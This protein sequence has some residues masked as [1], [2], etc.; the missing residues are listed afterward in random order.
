VSGELDKR[1][2]EAGED[3][4][5]ADDRV[6][7]AL[8]G[9]AELQPHGDEQASKEDQHQYVCTPAMPDSRATRATG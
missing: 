7:R 8:H 6:L 5:A 2:P 9:R 4:D 1:K 3:Q